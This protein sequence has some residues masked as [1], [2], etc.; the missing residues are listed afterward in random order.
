M[1]FLLDYLFGAALKA[2]FIL[3]EGATPIILT[4]S[5][6]IVRVTPSNPMKAALRVASDR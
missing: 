6:R 5:V 2:A 1:F 4:V 3:L